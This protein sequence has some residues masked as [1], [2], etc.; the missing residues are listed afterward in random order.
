MILELT[1]DEYQKLIEL[2]YLGEWMIN[3]QHDPEYEDE[4]A[5]AAV[6]Q[7]LGA[8]ELPSVER[9]A[10]TGNYFMHE[11]WTERLYDTYVADYDDHTFWD[12]LTERLALRDF[13][14]E[15]GLNAD[16]VDRED[17]LRELRLIE[18]RYR[19]EFEDHGLDRLDINSL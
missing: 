10:E 18:E 15:R 11:D 19:S 14:R 16:Q 2:A 17:N 13:A 3:A 5:G 12:E 8:G 4:A 9:D 6:Q 1:P 7:L